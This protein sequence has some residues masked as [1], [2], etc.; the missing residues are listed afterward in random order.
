MEAITVRS[1]QARGTGMLMRRLEKWFKRVL[2]AGDSVIA[3]AGLSVAGVVLAMLVTIA[4]WAMQSHRG[5]LEA[6]RREQI[7]AVASLIAHNAGLLLA[8]GDVAALRALAATAAAENELSVCRLTL[9]G[10]EVILSL[11]TAQ[12]TQTPLPDRWGHA[13]DPAAL[14][15]GADPGVARTIRVVAVP[16]RGSA[17]LEV[18]GRVEYPLSTAW[19]AQATVG[20]IGVVGLCMLW[21][22]YRGLR[23]RLGALAAIRGALALAARGERGGDALTV[24]EELGP[25]AAQWNTLLSTMEGLRRRAIEERM[26]EAGELHERHGAEAIG[27][28]DAMWLG[29]LV[30]DE[31]LQV[32]MANGAAGA[33]LQRRREE[34]VGSELVRAVAHPEVVSLVK[35]AVTGELRQRRAVEVKAA[36]ESGRAEAGVLRFSAKPMPGGAGRLALLLI[37]DVTQ[38]RVADESRNA[39]VA[40]ATHELRTPLTNIRLYVDELLDPTPKDARAQ[41][42]AINVISAEA[43]RLERIVSDM[44]SVSE[45]EAGSLRMHRDDVRL[46]TLLPELEEDYRAQ[47]ED[48]RIRLTFE[49]PPKMPVVQGDRDKLALALHNVLGNALKYTPEGGEVTVTVQADQKR[50]DIS[51]TDTGIGISPDEQE[52]IFEKFYRAKDE[53][54]RT[55]TGSG[56]GLALAREVVRRHGGDI[57]VQSRVDKGSTFTVSIPV[58]RA[59]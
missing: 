57:T 46:D 53:R 36:G 19:E 17:I 2:P 48:K 23:R 37:E 49:L 42:Q 29:V 35:S 24:S 59:A 7:N 28:V 4:W 44:L 56:L 39:F 14:S 6:S 50:V 15:T 41:E 54:V 12:V 40:Q 45:I 58:N 31:R 22:V 11:D 38:Q 16:G 20:T 10:G 3:W 26:V 1:A 9:P 55:I 34:M 43:R 13:V 47:A 18:G 33:L 5:G 21:L 8:S 27:A 25:E 30:V 52:L 51:V 32:R